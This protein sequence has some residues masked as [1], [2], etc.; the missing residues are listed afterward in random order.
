MHLFYKLTQITVISASTTCVAQVESMAALLQL[1]LL[2]V[3]PVATCIILC[4][5]KYGKYFVFRITLMS[6]IVK[7]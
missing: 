3:I 6:N 7:Y 2:I 4:D 5:G 1:V